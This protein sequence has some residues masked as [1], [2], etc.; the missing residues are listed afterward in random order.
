VYDLGVSVKGF[1]ILRH[2]DPTYLLE[3]KQ[4]GA[5]D[6]NLYIQSLDT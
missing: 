2:V 1:E 6:L 3:S 5:D 4:R